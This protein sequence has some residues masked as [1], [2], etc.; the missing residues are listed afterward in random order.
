MLAYGSTHGLGAER[1]QGWGRY[2]V[3][4]ITEIN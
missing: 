2:S 3:T 4:G 1:S